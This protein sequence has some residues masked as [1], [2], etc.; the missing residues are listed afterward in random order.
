MRIYDETTMKG[1]TPDDEVAI[2]KA[3]ANASNG[4]LFMDKGIKGWDENGNGSDVPARIVN[5]YGLYIAYVKTSLPED[6]EFINLR[7]A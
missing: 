7:G 4:Q 6:E 5:E 2:Q 3:S 1:L